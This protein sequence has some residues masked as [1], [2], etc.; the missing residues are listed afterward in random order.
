M[1][2]VCNAELTKVAASGASKR[3]SRKFI[4]SVRGNFGQ[5]HHPVNPIEYMGQH[6]IDGIMRFILTHPDMD[7]MDGIKP[8]VDTYGPLNFWD[9]D[10]TKEMDSSEWGSSPYPESTE[11]GGWV[12]VLKRQEGAPLNLG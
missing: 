10:N 7:H 3:M 6:N 12:S 9:T 2:D 1:I 4:Y 8:M 11:G 5:K